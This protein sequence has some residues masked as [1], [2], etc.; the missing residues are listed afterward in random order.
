MKFKEITSR[1]TGISCPIFGVSWNPP[2]PEVTMARRII[3]TLEDRR[4]LFTPSEVEVPSHCVKSVIEIRHFLTSELCHAHVSDALSA[5]IRAMR[6]A[7]RKFLD[8]VQGQDRE[9]VPFANQHCHWASWVFMDALGQMRGEFGIH[10]AQLAV[11]Y[12]L[13]VEK[14][15]ATIIPEK[16]KDEGAELHLGPY[17]RPARTRSEKRSR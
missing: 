17:S 2:E 5:H 8:R 4:V 13:D 1:L 9:V 15:L 14:D 7:C 6:A 11:R 12:G 16:D 10:I 3:T